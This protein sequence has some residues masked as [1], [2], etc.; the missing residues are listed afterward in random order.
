MDAN[1]PV[2][3]QDIR[4]TVRQLNAKLGPTLVSALAGARTHTA[5]RQWAEPEGAL[6]DAEAQARLLLALQVWIVVAE[7]DGDDVARL[8]FIGANPWLG[9]D[10]A[11][12]AIREDRS[13]EVLNAATAMATDAFSG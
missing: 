1:T 10:T 8:W 11:I 9:E 3:E 5:S 7:A 2:A 12:T 4:D 6:P 13:Q